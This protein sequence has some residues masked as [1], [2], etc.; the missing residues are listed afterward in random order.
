MHESAIEEK[1]ARSL[2]FTKSRLHTFN[3]KFLVHGSDEAATFL[4]LS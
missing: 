4:K 2:L 3:L 1:K